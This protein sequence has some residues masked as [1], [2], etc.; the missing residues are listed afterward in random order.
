MHI[1]IWKIVLNVM[2]VVLLLQYQSP[3]SKYCAKLLIRVSVL[4]T[5]GQFTCYTERSY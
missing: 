2:S 3:L 4:R 5:A 1:E